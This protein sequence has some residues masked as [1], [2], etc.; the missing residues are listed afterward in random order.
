[1]LLLGGS[2]TCAGVALSIVSLLIGFSVTGLRS[3]QSIT[4]PASLHIAVRAG[5]S[6]VPARADVDLGSVAR[7]NMTLLEQERTTRSVL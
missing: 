1:M 7:D 5:E 2:T 4:R 6:G 3:S